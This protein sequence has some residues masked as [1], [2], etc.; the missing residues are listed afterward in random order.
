[1][2]AKRLFHAVM[3]AALPVGCTHL[4]PSPTV[5]GPPTGTPRVLTASVISSID[6][7][8]EATL[9]QAPLAGLT[10]AV[11]IGSDPVYVG[12]YGL[13]DI[14]SQ[15]PAEG[16]TVYQIGSTTKIFTAAAIMQLVEQGELDLDDLV[17]DH[18]PNLPATMRAVQVHH[19]LGHTS[20]L[21]DLGDAAL[22]LDYS[23]EYTPHELMALY[24]ND[25]EPDFAPGSRFRYSNLGY[26][27]L[28]VLIENVSGLTYGEYLQQNIFNPL[29]LNSTT[30]C[31]TP[32]A[33]MAQGYRVSQ[34]EFRSTESSNMSIAYAA[35][36]ICST[37]SDLMAWQRSLSSG[38]VVSL[39]SYRQMTTPVE[40]S[41]G[42]RSSYGFGIAVG[43]FLG[44]SSIGHDGRTIGFESLL[45]H[46]SDDELTIVLLTNTNP[47]RSEVITELVATIRDTVLG[48]R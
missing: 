46:F 2:I 31:T 24:S 33:T 29:G 13:A 21:P 22:Y 30:Y 16:S 6:A 32:P 19:L 1:M 8:A 39:D 44:Q 34:G 43:K 37:A 26:H 45:V 41:Q 27:L 35:G 5:S 9:E 23:R 40:L 7:S 48:A 15:R 17:S 36:G 42:R 10:L 38:R 11:R 3:L 14:A 25:L 47:S 4:F 18:I 20:G 28:G 12:G